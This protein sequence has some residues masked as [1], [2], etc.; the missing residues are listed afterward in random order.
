MCGVDD[1]EA[2]RARQREAGLAAGR[3][4]LAPDRRALP[5]V[6]GE[7]AGPDDAEA[8][9]G[10]RAFAH[11]RRRGLRRAVAMMAR[12]AGAGSAATDGKQGRPRDR[13]AAA[14]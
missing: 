12:S 10:G 2:V 5:A 14:G 9:A 11:E 13:L 1:A 8:D 3:G 6:L 7:A 4:E